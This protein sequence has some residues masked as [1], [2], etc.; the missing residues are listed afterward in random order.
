MA[1]T[2]HDGCTSFVRWIFERFPDGQIE[3]INDYE[4]NLVD[5]L[6]EE[7]ERKAIEARLKGGYGPVP[8]YLM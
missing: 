1:F 7:F 4:F 8:R 2:F 6:L 5:H 3:M